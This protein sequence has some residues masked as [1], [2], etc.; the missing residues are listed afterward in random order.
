MRIYNRAEWGARP[1]GASVAHQDPNAIAEVFIHH[2]D[3]PGAHVRTLAEAVAIVQQEQAFHMDTRGWSDIGYHF[4]IVPNA[5]PLG[6]AFVFAGR[7][8]TVVPA[9]QLGHNENTAAICI[10][11]MDPE[12]LRDNT[13]WRAGRLARRIRSARRLRGH[14]EVTQTECPGAVIR[15]QLDRIAAIAGKQR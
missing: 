13:R 12:P 10:V 2:S 6:R 3:S 8:L 9:A 1:P 7:A 14:Y 5:A 11:Q 4:V 15:A